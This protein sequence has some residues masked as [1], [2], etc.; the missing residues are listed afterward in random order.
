MTIIPNRVRWTTADIVLFPDNGKRYEIV[1]GEL[2]VTKAP[3]WSHQEVT[4]RIFAKLDD[5]SQNTGAGRAALNPGV[6][7]TDEDNVIPD[8]VWASHDRLTL[9]LNFTQ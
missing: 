2:I 9:S 1:D 8:V 4:G 6:I 3:R 7:F 5:W